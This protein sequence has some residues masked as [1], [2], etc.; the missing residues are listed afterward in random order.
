MTTGP[1]TKIS[2]LDEEEEGS[3]PNQ[4]V[5]TFA[6]NRSLRMGKGFRLK[7]IETYEKIKQYSQLFTSSKPNPYAMS[8][9]IID[10]GRKGKEGNL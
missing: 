7:R 1:L 2:E 4:S 10:K 8:R 6:E 3:S 5:R 9:T